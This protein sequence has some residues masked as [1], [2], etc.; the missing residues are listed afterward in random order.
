MSERRVA[1]VTGASR[2]I[3]LSIARALA[4]A[5]ALWLVSRDEAALGEAADDLRLSAGDV[6][7]RACDLAQASGRRELAAEL[8]RAGVSVLVNNAGVARS[9]AL[10]RTDDAMWSHTIELDLTAPFELC[11]AVVPGMVTAGFGRIVNVCSTA[12]L[13]GYKYTSAYSA[14]KAGLLGLTR[15]LAHELAAK[16]VTVNAVCPGFSDTAIVADAAREIAQ[17]TG[18]DE[19]AARTTLAAFSPQGRLMSPD[20][21]AAAV[22]Y[23]VSDA[24]AGITG[25]ALPID[26][27]ETA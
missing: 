25:A 4:P 19:T 9:A 5:H 13:R 24:A 2:G 11:R 27:G 8:S 10:A 15:A 7:V 22:A 16:G 21:I 20:E 23:L 6:T 12:A 1:V 26:G 17:K 3:G 14:A 18:S